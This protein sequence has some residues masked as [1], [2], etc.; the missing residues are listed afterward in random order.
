MSAGKLSTRED[1]L[2]RG[3]KV[4]MAFLM[5]GWGQFFNQVTLTILLVIFNR[6]T[7][8]APPYSQFAAQYTF[9]ISF[10]L[11][12]I[13]TLWLVYYRTFK[14]RS[15]S[16]H[17][18]EAKK[19]ANVTGYDV[20]SLKT[21]FSNFGGRLFATSTG[22]FFNDV[23]FYGNKLFQSKLIHSPKYLASLVLTWHP[24]QFISVI[25]DN[26][27]SLLTTWNWNL[28]NIVVSL[29]GYY[30]A[31]LLIDNK[32]YGRKNMQQIGFLVCFLA[33]VIPA[34]NYKYYTS[35]A[36]IHSFQA[37][38]FLSSFF[39]QFGPNSVTFLV[40]GE[41]YP[42]QVRASAHG[43]SAM[44][45]KS[46][47]LLASVLYN[48]IDN[49]TKFLVVP[50]F[51]LAGML[52]TLVWLPDTTGL[53]L[54]EQERRWQCILD[55]RPEDYHG[56]AIHPQHLSLWERW[57]GAGKNYHPDLDMKAKIRD[58]RA[59]WEERRAGSDVESADFEQDDDGDITQDIHNYFVGNPPNMSNTLKGE[60][61]KGGSLGSE[62]ADRESAGVEISLD[63]KA[64]N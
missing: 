16:K 1:R 48:Y 64:A 62:S 41:V 30:S 3:R 4:T 32:M 15:A 24:G 38:Y 7:G 5:Q 60:K 43:F 27:D 47:A 33:F 61:L 56:I 19:K 34:F 37:L 25:S 42:T 12:A 49:P 39:N 26:P 14:M 54:K 10:A 29:A 23:F 46:G 21:T 9:R 58:L 36:G 57:R 13:G 59:E 40:A 17:L 18:E 6:G 20:K 31:A 22:W 2:H 11:P 63:E 52:V 35:P 28:V 53:D 45:G 8:G 51:G 50:W 44:V 55:G